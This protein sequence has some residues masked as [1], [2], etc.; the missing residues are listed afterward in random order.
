MAGRLSFA[1]HASGG[2]DPSLRLKSGYAQDDTAEVEVKQV[3]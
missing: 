3:S 2:R 1:G